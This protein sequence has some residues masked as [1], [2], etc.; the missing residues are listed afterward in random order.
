MNSLRPLQL[1]SE[2]KRVPKGFRAPGLQPQKSGAPGLQ[3]RINRAPGLPKTISRVPG[4]ANIL[5]FFSSPEL[6]INKYV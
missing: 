2:L 5:V 6:F 3:A 1:F 4:S